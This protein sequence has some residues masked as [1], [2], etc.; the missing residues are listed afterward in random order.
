[1]SERPN[2]VFVLTDDQGYGDL[3]CHGNPVLKTPNIDKLYSQSLRFTDFHVGPTCAPTRSGLFTGHHAN[4]TG[5]WHTVGGRSLLRGNETTLA[6]VFKDN[7]YQTGLFGKWHLG[8]N[9]PY[10]P[11]DRGFETT[12]CHGGGGISQ[13]ADHW[14]ND[15]FDDTYSVNGVPTAFEGCCTDVFFGLA[16][17]Y[18]REHQQDP[19]LCVITCNAPHDPYNVDAKYS[20]PYRDKVSIDRSNFYGMISNID[21]NVGKLD[22]LLDELN[23]RE[24]TIVI[25]MT[26]NGTSMRDD[27]MYTCGLRGV[28]GS[29]Y[30]GGHRVPFFLRWPAG[31][32]HQPADVDTLAAHVDFMPTLMDL[33]GFDLT[34]YQHLN[35]HGQ[36]LKPLM[37]GENVD[38]FDRALVTDSQRLP[39]PVK[40]RYSAVMTQQWR[41][42]NGKELYEIHQDR[43]QTHDIASE[44][45][46]VVKQLRVDYENWWKIVSKQFDEAIPIIIGSPD[47]PEAL[48]TAH[49]WRDPTDPRS[50]DPFVMESNEYLVYNQS[51]VR[52]GLGENG[53]LE[54]QIQ[55]AGVY[56][57]ELRRWPREEVRALT[58]GI[59]HSDEG[60]RSDVIHPR[61]REM[62]SGGVAMPFTKAGIEIA[63]LSQTAA[64]EPDSQAAVF[65]LNLPQGQTHLKTWFHSD[66]GLERG[67]YYVYVRL[68]GE[69]SLA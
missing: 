57:F 35:L 22:A 54:I 25:Y 13:V 67:A 63:G 31:Q 45:P 59:A 64:I 28:K 17:D 42:I 19:F 20:S 15:Y 52:Q 7:G 4:S 33:C 3:G 50:D 2:I 56:R 8:D 9:Y 53:Y 48:L 11:Q 68:L 18:I 47:E 29:P 10:R 62:Y 46:Q 65:E 5:V 61:H 41:L 32:L 24:N 34:Q 66:T 49:D 38:G 21:E 36:S 14:G 30:D 43:G 60:W 55:Q 26:D 16:S 12:V 1:M 23:L 6:N 44:H 40:W 27:D 58:Q 69:R 51:Q 39:N 37:T